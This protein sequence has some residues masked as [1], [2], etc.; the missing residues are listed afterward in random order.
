MPAEHAQPETL[1]ARKLGRG[2]R[3][4]LFPPC[5]GFVA[6]VN[7]TESPQIY[8]L[9]TLIEYDPVPPAVLKCRTCTSYVDDGVLVPEIG[10]PA[11]RRVHR[12][13]VPLGRTALPRPVPY[14]TQHPPEGDCRAIRRK[15]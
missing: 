5:P 3:L 8:P 11:Q 15:A 9:L 13:L 6:R 14:R 4:G 2:W 7:S 1:N 12:W 10:W